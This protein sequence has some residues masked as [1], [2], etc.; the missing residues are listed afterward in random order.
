[1]V[2]LYFFSRLLQTHPSFVSQHQPV[3]SEPYLRRRGRHDGY[4]GGCR[5]QRSSS[6]GHARLS[7]VDDPAIALGFP[8][9]LLFAEHP[10]RRFGEMP[11]HGPDRLRVALPPGQALIEAAHVAVGRAPAMETDRVRR[12]DERPLEVAV[13]IRTRPPEPA[14]PAARV[15]ARRGPRIGRQSFGA[16]KPRDIAHLEGNH[17]RERVPHAWQ[18][19]EPLNRRR[20]LEGGLNPLFE[21]VHLPAQLLDLPEQLLA[22]VRRV[23]REKLEAL[24]QE[25]TAPYAE[26][27]AHV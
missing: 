17:H 4:L 9:G 3:S 24:P 7:P 6:W 18:G 27:I 25:R 26:E 22:G 1:M 12:F 15:H 10:I 5:N 19:Q 23:R 14:L 8:I 2:V 20:Q 13:D 11:S 21:R 16:R